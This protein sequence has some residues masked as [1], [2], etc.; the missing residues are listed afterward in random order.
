MLYKNVPWYCVSCNKSV[1]KII[2][3]LVS[4]QAKQD[5]MESELDKIKREWS[6]V[7]AKLKSVGEIDRAADVMAKATDFMATSIETKLEAS[8]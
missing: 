3:M 6:K 5:H 4:V 7:R 8:C 2:K 1:S